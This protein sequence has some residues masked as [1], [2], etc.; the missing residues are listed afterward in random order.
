MGYCRRPSGHVH[1]GHVLKNL[2]AARPGGH[3]PRP[4]GRSVRLGRARAGENDGSAVAAGRLRHRALVREDARRSRGAPA[5][6]SAEGDDD[7][8]AA[9]QTVPA[10]SSL[11]RIHGVEQTT[12][13]V[14]AK[15]VEMK[16]E[17]D[18]DIH[19][20]I[21]DPTGAA[22]DDD[23]RVPAAD[24][25]GAARRRRRG[26]RCAA[27]GAPLSLRAVAAVELVQE[28][29]R[30]GDDHGRSASS[31]R[32]TARP[33]SRRT[34]SSSIRSSAS[35]ARRADGAP[36]PP[37]PPPSLAAEG[38]CAASYPDCLHPASAA[39]PELCGHP[40]QQLPRPLG[41]PGS[42]SAPLRREPRR[43]RL[44]ELTA[45]RSRGRSA[46]ARS[47]APRP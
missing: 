37:P 2:Q 5:Q 38:S 8:R 9:S 32:S 42:R 40:V 41:R 27:R 3:S 45:S 15:L 18:S 12:Y 16:L 19:L 46:R 11:R 23:R 20:V 35:A 47:R 7:S 1:D 24:L 4:G 29:E 10:I 33:A 6:S 22:A 21:A 26:R 17:D 31:T 39:R 36:A 43:R 28:A 34:A 14:R 13:R 30:H 44:R 25:H